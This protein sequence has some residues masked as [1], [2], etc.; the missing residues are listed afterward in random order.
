M[1]SNFQLIL[2]SKCWNNACL[3]RGNNYAKSWSNP[4]WCI[5]MSI[6]TLISHVIVVNAWNFWIIGL[7]METDCWLKLCYCIWIFLNFGFP[8]RFYI[9]VWFY[10]LFCLSKYFC[11]LRIPLLVPLKKRAEVYFFNKFWHLKFYYFDILNDTFW[12]FQMVSNAQLIQCPNAQIHPNF[13]T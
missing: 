9:Y 11:F 5:L 12:T 10:F 7:L 4:R 13:G 6:V 3:K 1:I 8:F 2:K